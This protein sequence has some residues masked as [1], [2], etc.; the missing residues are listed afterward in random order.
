M[1]VTRV[2]ETRVGAVEVMYAPGDKR[3]MLFFPGGHCSAAVGCGWSLYTS[4]GHG[5]LSFSRPGYG[6]T[7]VGR[8]TA[9]EFVPAVA[10]SCEMLAI[11]ESAGAVGVS[12]GGL[13]AIQVAVALPALVPRLALHSC[14]PS[15]HAFPD[16][17]RE[18]VLGPIA[19][20]PGLQRFAW[21]AVTRWVESDAGLHR[22]VGTLS[23]RPLREWW[24]TWSEDDRTQA[25]ELF[26]T[27][28]SGAGFANDLQQG[29]PDRGVYRRL[30]QA[31][32]SCPTLVTA[33]RD[34]AGVA[35]RHAED[36]AHTIPTATFVELDAPSHLF[37]IGPTRAQVQGAVSAFIAATG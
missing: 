14:A 17:A 7:D 27:M 1:R 6:L 3:P 8:L 30:F 13:Q 22:M 31:R 25:R 2:L 11:E 18:S 26:K 24:H 34:D 32:V 16:T 36:F 21:A 33:S 15:T 23:K 37:W 19:F 10:E 9:E 20:G 4:L 5:V 28:R 35:F 29:R 12:F